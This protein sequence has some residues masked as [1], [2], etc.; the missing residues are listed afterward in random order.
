VLRSANR[1]R[2][3][4]RGTVIYLR[5]SPEQLYRRLRHDTKRP[6]LQVAD[7]LGRLRDMHAQREPLYRECAHFVVDTHGAPLPMLVGRVLSQLELMPAPPAEPPQ[8]E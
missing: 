7:P 2:L 3:H 4:E 6:L 8:T 1:Q 5:S